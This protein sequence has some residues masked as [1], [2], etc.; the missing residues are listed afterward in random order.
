MARALPLERQTIYTLLGVRYWDPALD[1]AV[2]DGLQVTA[3]PADRPEAV[4]T[5]FR[6]AAGVVAFRGLAGLRH[7]EYP[8]EGIEPWEAAPVRF[9]V[10]ALD[11]RRRYLPLV[12]AVHVPHRGVFPSSA[13]H[14]PDVPAAPGCW[15]FSAPTRGAVPGFGVVRAQLAV[16]ESAEPVAYAVVEVAI[17]GETWYGISD[18]AGQVVVVFPLPDFTSLTGFTSPVSVMPRQSWPVAV[19]VRH[20]GLVQE[21]PVRAVAPDL[22]S[23]FEQPGRDIWLSSGGGTGESLVMDFVFG[24][25]LVLQTPG[26]PG[27]WL[28]PEASPL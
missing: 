1:E 16:A 28:E 4:T 13:L 24:E 15:L 7:L 8:A 26:A 10:Q 6:T 17:A 27:L 5:A 12:F 23:L 25:E 9:I 22:R 19:R 21:T 3:W 2:V 11:A 18:A 14:S 20:A